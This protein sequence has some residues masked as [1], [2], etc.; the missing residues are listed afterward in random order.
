MSDELHILG[1][2]SQSLLRQ[3][4]INKLIKQ[5]KLPSLT[6]KPSLQKKPSG[7][8]TERPNLKAHLAEKDCEQE[9]A[10]GMILVNQQ[11]E[12]EMILRRMIEI[13][14]K[15]DDMKPYAWDIFD[16]WPGADI[17]G[18]MIELAYLHGQ[19]TEL[20]ELLDQLKTKNLAGYFSVA[21]DLRQYIVLRLWQRSMEGVLNHYLHQ[22]AFQGKLIRLEK[23]FVFWSLHGCADQERAWRFFEKFEVDV[24]DAV[25]EFGSQLKLTFSFFALEVGKMALSLRKEGVAKRYL[26]EIAPDSR[27]F[28]ESLELLLKCKIDLDENGHCIYGRRLYK[29]S[30][31]RNRVALIRTFLQDVRTKNGVRHQERAALNQVLV[32]PLKWLPESAEAW[33]QLSRLLV[34][35]VDL[36]YLLPNLFHVYR[37]HQTEFL[38]PIFEKALWEP[39]I[40]LASTDQFKNQ[41]W[42]GV[43]L[44]HKFVGS[45]YLNYH[46][47]WEAKDAIDASVNGVYKGI[48]WSK[49]HQNLV[50]QVSRS[51]QVVESDREDILARIK[52]VTSYLDISGGEVKSF[53]NAM[54]SQDIPV[55]ERL[56][57]MVKRR[58]DIDTELLLIQKQSEI[59]HPTNDLIDRQW[60][61][62]CEKKHHDL[63]WR[64]ATLLHC[65]HALNLEVE[66]VWILSGE[67]KR[68]PGARLIPQEYLGIALAGM[69]DT[70]KQFAEAMLLVGAKL[71]ELLSIINRRVRS[72]K[73]DKYSLIDSSLEDVIAKSPWLYHGRRV[74]KSHPEKDLVEKPPF[75]T[76]VADNKW[77]KILQI[78]A[79]RI[80]V[81]SWKWDI[82]WLHDELYGLASKLNKSGDQQLSGK[83]GKWLRSLSPLQRKAWR[84]LLHLSSG[85][86]R[87]QAIIT[88]SK[89]IC[90]LTTMMYQ[91]HVEALESLG[92]SE[93][94]LPIRWDL[95]K[96]IL[97]SEYSNYRNQVFTSC[98][99]AIPKR[100]PFSALKASK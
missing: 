10:P 5:F 93:C 54:E 39:L 65:R 83:T 84:S 47:L 95:E 56:L 26:E 17:A 18:K 1:K 55:L 14:S 79:D 81:S 69:K 70:E 33:S 28:K 64:A 60:Q 8:E 36:E 96:F 13:D 43:A 29:E 11:E 67:K 100:V 74:Y 44:L 80:G 41:Y 97:S 12:S 91:H 89:L 62:A 53:V 50:Y 21:T 42:H 57:V 85:L 61:I 7:S 16:R 45:H 4:R 3:A 35:Y 48:S 68:D 59:T 15:W 30:E 22:K 76:F 63:A 88:L 34:E 73:V 86:E 49:L 27:E 87:E 40:G 2:E 19:T 6:D 52:I 75:M 20:V 31:W 66:Q 37:S 25:K 24:V 72:Q 99:F 90:R 51:H 23:L 77:T 38:S 9:S 32:K 71:P 58:H 98:D 78:I 82:V 46:L 94:Y 92:Y